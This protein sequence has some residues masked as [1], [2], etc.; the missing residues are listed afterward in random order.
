MLAELPGILTWYQSHGYRIVDMNGQSGVKPLSA[1][2]KAGLVDHRRTPAGRA[3]IIDAGKGA[4][5]VAGWV[6]DPDTSAKIKVRIQDDHRWISTTTT[7]NKNL[8]GVV[9]PTGTH[10]FKVTFKA[11]RGHHTVCVFGENVGPGTRAGLGCRD[12]TVR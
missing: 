5:T 7:A 9:G 12:V 10:E 8:G 1:T 2:Q 11:A 6:K 3:A 4:V